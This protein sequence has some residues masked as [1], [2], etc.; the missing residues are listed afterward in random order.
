MVLGELKERITGE[1]VPKEK[2][3]VNLFDRW[4]SSS[5]TPWVTV[6]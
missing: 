5:W 1:A 4:A 6:G 2:I 3:S